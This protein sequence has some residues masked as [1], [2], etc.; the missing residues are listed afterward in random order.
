MPHA[1]RDLEAGDQNTRV[2][3]EPSALKR[4]ESLSEP[5]LRSDASTISNYN[6]DSF[7]NHTHVEPRR[8]QRRSEPEGS[9]AA[10][11][12]ME[13]TVHNSDNSVRDMLTP[14][15]LDIFLEAS[16]SV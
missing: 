7:E 10:G 14:L 13:A 1:G 16:L 12:S 4:A 3:M 15:H 6:N 5:V 9:V 2:K 8:K 11:T